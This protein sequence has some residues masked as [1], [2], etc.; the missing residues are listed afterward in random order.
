MRGP[1]A[2]SPGGAQFRDLEERSHVAGRSAITWQGGRSHVAWRGHSHVISILMMGRPDGMEGLWT[3][4]RLLTRTGHAPFR[5]ATCAQPAAVAV[6]GR[7]AGSGLGRPHHHCRNGIDIIQSQPLRSSF[8]LMISFTF[9][10]L[11]FKSSDSE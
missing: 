5:R 2:A 6:R 4:F 9:S 10:S 7:P 1:E 8:K 3:V 11:I